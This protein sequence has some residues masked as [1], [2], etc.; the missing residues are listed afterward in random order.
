MR[1]IFVFLFLCAPMAEGKDMLKIT[2]PAF[3]HEQEIPSRFTCEGEDISPALQ[4]SS[5]PVG[6]KSL[7]LIVDDPDAPDPAAP[8]M[9][10]V[11]WIVFNLSPTVQEIPE[12]FGKAQPITQVFKNAVEGKNSWDRTSF[13]GA[14]PPIGSHRYYFKIYA[15]DTVLKLDASATKDALLK[16]IEGHILEQAQLMGRYKKKN[17]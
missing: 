16:A 9:T 14:C 2:S 12:G 3:N 13:G 11:H 17:S 15:L 4:I 8:K 6:T 7:A 1:C 5:I 10:W